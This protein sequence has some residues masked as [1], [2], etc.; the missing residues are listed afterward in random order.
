MLSYT[1]KIY[2]K[3]ILLYSINR[4]NEMSRFIINSI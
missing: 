3:M 4:D 1:L 2:I